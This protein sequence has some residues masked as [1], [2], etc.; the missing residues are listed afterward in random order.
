MA[1]TK[2][3]SKKASSKGSSIKGA[4][5]SSKKSKKSSKFSSQKLRSL[6][7]T[8]LLSLDVSKADMM[9]TATASGGC[10]ARII[11]TVEAWGGGDVQ[12]G[13]DTLSQLSVNAPCTQ[14]RVNALKALLNATFPMSCSTT[15]GSLIS[16][17]CPLG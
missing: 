9:V 1:S 3:T 14:Q 15:V 16:R 4:K 2:K 13:S 8:A 17:L 7:V 11:A 12:S 5:R 10:P 6:P